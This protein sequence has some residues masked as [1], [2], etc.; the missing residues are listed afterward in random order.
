[1]NEFEFVKSSYSSD[2]ANTECVEVATNVAGTVALRDSKQTDGPVIRV[3]D[4]AW[5]AFAGAQ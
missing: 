2:Q 1:M 3:T 5:A 4:T